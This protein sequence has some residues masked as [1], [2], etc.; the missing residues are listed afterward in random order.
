MDGFED[1]NQG[2]GLRSFAAVECERTV[3]DKTTR[4]RRYF[5][6]SLDGTS[7]QVLA[8]AVRGQWGIENKLHWVLDA[9]FGEDACRVRKGHGTENLSRLRR[10]A[11]NPLRREKTE[12]LAIKNNRLL[13]G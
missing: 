4:E 5:I 7:A 13:A 10:M 3:G 1:R 9:C 11:L 6:S 2:S 8:R 12:R